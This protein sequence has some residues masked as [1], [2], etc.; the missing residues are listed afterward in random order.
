MPFVYQIVGAAL[1]GGGLLG[2]ALAQVPSHLSPLTL[3]VAL[4]EAQ[5]RS[6]SL[7]A[8]DASSRAAQDMAVAAGRLPDPTLRLSMDNLP[9]EGANAFSV[10]AE[11]MTMRAVGLA[12]T[13]VGADKRH[14][15]SARYAREGDAAQAQRALAVSGL[16][17]QTALAWFDRYYQQQLLDLLSQQRTETALQIEAAEAAYRTGRGAQ[18]DVWAAQSAVARLDDRILEARARAANARSTLARWVGNVADAPL[19]SAPS[20]ARTRY[21][22]EAPA[23]QLERHPDL[24]VLS[25][26]QALAQAE[27][28]MAQQDKQA[29][30]SAS[31]MFSQRGPAY[32]NMVSVGVTI[33]LQWDQQNR[34]DRELSAR[35]A[36]V[37]QI[38]AERDEMA[39]AHLAQTQ[40][41]L[42]S[43]QS[44]LT[45]LA[46]YDQTL[47]VLAR[48]RTQ[49]ALAAYRGGKLPL[50]GVLEARQME[51]DTQ[52]ERLRLEMQTAALWSALEYLLPDD[53]AV[54]NPGTNA[55]TTSAI[56]PPPHSITAQEH[57]Q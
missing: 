31:F 21:T 35:L 53:N 52:V 25:S 49:A 27:A 26:R 5:A 3:D 30:W 34:Q 36:K 4:H 6:Q 2:G 55:T 42:A 23:R 28:D 48:E 29:D 10:S 32:A 8:Q 1:L 51:I 57:A 9:I 19:G 46:H 45:R 12:Q 47:I 18:A 56:N 40:T 43:W 11:P 44:N 39:R 41:W 16:R 20:L 50:T 7:A 54:T 33:P 24:G 22:R 17:Q 37:E 13:F 14:A 15:R 38:R